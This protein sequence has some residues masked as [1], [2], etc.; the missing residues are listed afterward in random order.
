MP[1]SSHGR[2]A[3]ARVVP[4]PAAIMSYEYDHVPISGPAGG[5][6][7]CVAARAQSSFLG[8]AAKISSFCGQR[9]FF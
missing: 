2:A 4:W 1:K 7:I 3:K 6:A 9:I 5:V 8:K